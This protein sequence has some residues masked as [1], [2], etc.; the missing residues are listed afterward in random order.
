MLIDKNYHHDIISNL[1][2]CLRMAILTHLPH[3]EAV[4]T[5]V[6]S[7]NWKYTWTKLSHIKLDET[8]WP[9][10]SVSK[11][12]AFLTCVRRIFHIVLNHEGPITEVTIAL[13]KLKD[14]PEIDNLLLI[15]SK[16]DVEGL[17][18]KI[19]AGQ[20]LL[21]SSF[22][23]CK[24]LKHVSLYSYRVHLPSNFTGFNQL[25]AIKMDLV[26]IGS[27]Q[28][29]SLVS[30]CPL[31][32]HLWL[33]ISSTYTYESLEI[34]APNLKCFKFFS[35]IKDIC[36]KNSPVLKDV[37]V[38]DCTKIGQHSISGYSKVVELFSSLPDLRF[39]CFDHKFTKCIASGGVPATPCL[40]A[41]H[42]N[43][44]K[45]CSFCLEDTVGMAFVLFLLRIAPNLQDITIYLDDSHDAVSSQSPSL[46][47]LDIEEYSDVKLDKLRMVML[48]EF[49][50]AKNQLR[51]AKLLLIKS[52]V[53]KKMIIKANTKVC[54]E[55]QLLILKELV[56]FPRPSPMA[57]IHYS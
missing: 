1:P 29:A 18:L 49:A 34:H 56:R 31:L 37:W 52:P 46:H 7:S 13:S 8:L 38:V 14:C 44:V 50:G 55:K 28:L 11:D 22:F 25:L 9:K 19:Q 45:L 35:R 27:E 10:T 36:F 26:S 41:V 5:S 3:L 40:T 12:S 39:L 6:L 47:S 57:E 24:N 42:L 53:L 17:T 16:S 30:S 32:E 23:K 2:E 21:P 4:R 20:C 43:A 54:T 48:R 51:L 15:L 33:R